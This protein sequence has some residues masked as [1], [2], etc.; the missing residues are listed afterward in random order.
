MEELTYF[1]VDE[2]AQDGVIL[3]GKGGLLT[4]SGR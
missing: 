2:L 4:A 1:L 3:Q